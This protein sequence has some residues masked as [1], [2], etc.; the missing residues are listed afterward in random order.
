MR[1]GRPNTPG[2]R[3]DRPQGEGRVMAAVANAL[4][5]SAAEQPEKNILLVTL[6]YFHRMQLKVD[7]VC[8][9]V[10]KTNRES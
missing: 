2:E 5:P 6:W 10:C 8:V 3:K 1:T 9:C 7:S 4:N